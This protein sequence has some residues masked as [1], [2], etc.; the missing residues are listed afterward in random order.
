MYYYYLL[1]GTP[2]YGHYEE[3]CG[4]IASLVELTAQDVMGNCF[5]QIPNPSL[6][7]GYRYLGEPVPGVTVLGEDYLSEFEAPPAP[8][9]YWDGAEWVCFDVAAAAE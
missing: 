5:L 2:P 4:Y 8:S 9:C 1:I 7:I 6:L 3:V